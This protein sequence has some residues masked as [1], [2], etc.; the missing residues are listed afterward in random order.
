MASYNEA[1]AIR[2]VLAEIEEAESVVLARSGITLD[3]LLVDD[4][5]P[6]E[7]ARIALEEAKRLGLNL[8]VL[9]GQPM[10]P[11]NAFLRGSSS[12]P[13]STGTPDFIV[14]LDSDGQHDARQ[15]PDFSR[16]AF[17]A[18]RTGMTI[19]SRWPRVGG[20]SPGTPIHRAAL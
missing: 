20:R 16:A 2:P 8:E 19:G 5:S 18:R 7:T 14:T 10:G 11:G 17:L 6:D 13:Y 15:M 3:I 9:T 1:S 12:T 4:R